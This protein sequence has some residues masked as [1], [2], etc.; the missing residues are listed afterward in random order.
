M[1]IYYNMIVLFMSHSSL[2]NFLGVTDP[3]MVRKKFFC[4]RIIF[5]D[6][7]HYYSTYT[8]VRFRHIILLSVNNVNIHHKIFSGIFMF[9]FLLYQL[10]VTNGG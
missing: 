9:R 3:L 8:V 6:T 5:S 1:Q 4:T 10:A 7:F 2:A